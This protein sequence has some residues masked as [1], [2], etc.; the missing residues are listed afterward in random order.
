MMKGKIRFTERNIPT[1][2]YL[3]SKEIID[4]V[5]F[6]AAEIAK[7]NTRI[8][9]GSEFVSIVFRSENKAERA[10]GLEMRIRGGMAI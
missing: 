5:S 3:V 8:S 9:P 4:L 10:K 7:K 6:L 2:E 1:E